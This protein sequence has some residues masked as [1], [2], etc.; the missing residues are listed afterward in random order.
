MTEIRPVWQL[1]QQSQLVSLEELAFRSASLR[2]LV[3]EMVLAFPM[4]SRSGPDSRRRRVRA[5]RPALPSA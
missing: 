4:V 1:A 5:K 3:L 2:R